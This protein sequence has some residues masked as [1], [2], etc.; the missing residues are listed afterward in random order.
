M[1]SR[2]Y[3][4]EDAEGFEGAVL[5]GHKDTVVGA[6][7][8]KDTSTIY[9]VGR[10]G[11]LFVW[12]MQ[13]H[14]E[15][16]GDANGAG[17]K[18]KRKGDDGRSIRRI[19]RW[20]AAEKHYFNQNHAK[21]TC[22][23]F[24]APSNLLVVGFNSGIFGIWE[25]PDFNNIHTLS[26][27][28]KKITSVA[29]NA[30]GEWLAFGS[31]AFGQLLVWEWQSESY[32]LKQQGHQH[33]MT[34]LSY[35]QDGQFIAT[36]GDDGKVKLWN[37]QSGFC[38]V[39][40]TD[41]AAGIAAIEFAK[42]GQV[43]FSASQDG[44]VRAFDLVRYRN[45]RT[46]TTPT[47]VQFSCL[48]VDPSGD[49]VCAGS[50]DTF[51]IFVWSVQTG[52]LLDI[53]SGHEAPISGLSFSPSEGMVASSSWDRTVRVWDVFG[54]DKAPESFEHQSEVLAVAWRPDGKQFASTTLDGQVSFWDMSVGKLT[55]TIE[56][57]KDIAGGRKATDRMTAANSQA[58]KHFTSLCYTA[59]GSTVLAGGNS[60]YVCIYDI[61]SHSLL[62]RFQISQ[63]LSLDGMKEFLNS[64]NMTEAGP[65]DLIDTSGEYSD[66]EDRLDTSLP[67]V[68]KGDASLRTTR[69]E[70]RTK[71]V[72]FAP[73]GRSWGAASTEGLLI[74]SLDETLTFDPF[75]LEIDITPDTVL[76]AL[77]EREYLRSLVMSF[78]LGE[79]NIT[80]KVYDAIPVDSV[81]LVVRDIPVKYLERTMGLLVSAVEAS[82]RIEFHLTWVTCLFKFHGKWIRE[83]YVEIGSGV[84]ALQKG[85]GKMY[86]DVSKVCDDNTYTLRFLLNAMERNQS[87]VEAAPMEIDAVNMDVVGL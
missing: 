75:D 7:F 62:K 50:M 76:E 2:V 68:R 1:T 35:S 10:D 5:A 29:I 70:V 22:A 15:G 6:W 8:S 80:Q 25:L 79:K 38:F 37:T 18:K 14:A 19:S 63:N 61:P 59:D 55:T 77:S 28:Q 21:V 82:P 86:E 48:A 72:R 12:K 34:C 57:R 67:G 65:K 43:V 87:E 27:S 17:G 42:Q 84:R 74:Y 3:A 69:P 58:N 9:T 71:A 64:S 56:G 16:D 26:I 41:H 46:F 36:G 47:P 52:K 20:R 24:H 85:V 23:S 30:T 33:D 83:R 60:K 39:T 44:T 49:V 4:M 81:S 31:S 32:V 78:R 66:L 11:A 40:F 53:L 54:R 13:E 51:E 73:T 45:F